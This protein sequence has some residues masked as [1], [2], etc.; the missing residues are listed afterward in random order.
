[1]E[2]PRVL[3]SILAQVVDNHGIG[4][5]AHRGYLR[6]KGTDVQM[7]AIGYSVDSP[8]GPGIQVDVNVRSKRLL[9]DRMLIES[10]SAF[11]ADEDESIKTAFHDF[12][13]QSL[14]TILAAFVDSRLDEGQTF[15][16]DWGSGERAWNVCLGPIT[17]KVA[18]SAEEFS[19]EMLQATRF[20]SFVGALRDAYLREASHE[21]HWLR[22]Y[23]GSLH[24]EC[25]AREVLLDNEEWQ[26]GLDILD[27]WQWPAGPD[28]YSIRELMIAVPAVEEKKR[29]WE[30]R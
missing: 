21:L 15:W 28:F 25:I 20:D 16:D 1:M 9:Q 19:L 24:G 23:R 5:S 22:I 8:N 12:C 10:A 2:S 7:Q 11:Q 30:L 17:P 18:A 29:W 3:T 26:A 13:I 27:H 14:H 4:W 6:I